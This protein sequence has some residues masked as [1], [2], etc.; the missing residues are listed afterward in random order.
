[1][2]H[3]ALLLTLV[4]S[5]AVAAFPQLETGSP[6][7]FASGEP[8]VNPDSV[9]QP[10]NVADGALLI[11]ASVVD[12]NDTITGITGYTEFASSPFLCG[13]SACNVQFYFK[14]ADGTEDGVNV[15]VT[16][17][18]TDNMASAFWSITGAADPTVQEP[19]VL[20]TA[21]NSG[22]AQDPPSLTPTGGAKDYLWM[23]FDGRNNGSTTTTFDGS[24]SNTGSEETTDIGGN[25][26]IA[27]GTKE[28]NASVEDP[29][30]FEDQ[31]TNFTSCT[32]AIHP[33]D[34]SVVVF[35]RRQMGY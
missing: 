24:Y 2:R 26:A 27:W 17:S 21:G 30:A 14:D 13:S 23:I 3:L 4:S 31:G 19:E 15:N 5:L 20:C 34:D 6:V 22:D 28:E 12:T 29:D 7:S 9:T 10:P 16:K 32:I 1:V 35:R 33:A 25:V 8:D 11:H 18:S